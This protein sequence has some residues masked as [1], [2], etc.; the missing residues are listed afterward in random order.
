M[1]FRAL[2]IDYHAEA[3]YRLWEQ[4]EKKPHVIIRLLGPGEIALVSNKDGADKSIV[5]DAALNSLQDKKD[6]SSVID[7]SS[8]NAPSMIEE[9]ENMIDTAGN[10]ELHEVSGQ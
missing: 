9:L 7:E 2:N 1:K 6:D 10:Q 4:R 3:S 5:S 8:Y